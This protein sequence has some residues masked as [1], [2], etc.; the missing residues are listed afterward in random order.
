MTFEEA[1]HVTAK[2]WFDALR[3]EVRWPDDMHKAVMACMSSSL[4]LEEYKAWIYPW[5]YALLK[6][7]CESEEALNAEI[8]WIQAQPDVAHNQTHALDW[9]RMAYISSAL[10]A[11]S[12]DKRA[13][14]AALGR[15]WTEAMRKDRDRF[16]R[17]FSSKLG[18]QSAALYERLYGDVERRS[19]RILPD[20]Q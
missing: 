9:M 10:Y 15:L 18:K 2:R 12:S 17:V 3:T 20:V 13:T 1:Y 6:A 19:V 7:G 8:A 5:M 4:P 11:L 16:L 14:P